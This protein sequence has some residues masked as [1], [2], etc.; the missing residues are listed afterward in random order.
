MDH[1][2]STALHLSRDPDQ[3]A[4][5]LQ[6]TYLRAYRSWHQFTPGTNCK[7]WLL[8]ILYNA[9]RNRYRADRSAPPLV[10]L[11]EV[12]HVRDADPSVTI[13]ADDPVDLLSMQ[14]LDSDVEAA[15]RALPQEYRTAVILVD[16]QELTYE[17]AAVVVGSPVGTIRS[18]LSRG[19]TLLQRALH[20]YA[21]E[22]GLLRRRS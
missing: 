9:F 6:E 16:V 5:L 22:R 11:D 18:R 12:A 19:R 7:A 4:D 1:L 15:L 2:Y 14:V 20:A 13:V 21:Q 17:E 3:A 10:E 8:T